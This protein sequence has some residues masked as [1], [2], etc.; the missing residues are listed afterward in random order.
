MALSTQT[1]TEMRPQVDQKTGQY[2]D[3]SAYVPSQFTTV[4]ATGSDVAA[5]LGEM[6]ESSR[7]TLQ[8]AYNLDQSVGVLDVPDPDGR[9]VR[10]RANQEAELRARG[11][12]QK[13]MKPS[14]LVQGLGKMRQ[15]NVARQTVR[16]TET[17]KITST[18]Y[19]DGTSDVREEP[20]WR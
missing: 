18:V 16:W 10:I 13:S 7:V 9:S 4:K 20:R 5:L 14:F 1:W 19:K 6:K 3:G 17:S 15:Q 2:V 12:C 11:Y 8:Q